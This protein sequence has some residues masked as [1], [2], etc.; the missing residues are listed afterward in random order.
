MYRLAWSRG[1]LQ[2]FRKASKNNQVLQAKIFSVL[3]ELCQNPFDPRLKTHKL[4]GK[5]A[6]LWAF[7]VEYDCRVVFA[8]EQMADAEEEV[9][10]LVDI[11]KHDEVY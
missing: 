5:L 1:F 3:E 10:V 7:Q 9:I 2:G 6:G 4:R 8:F 11:G